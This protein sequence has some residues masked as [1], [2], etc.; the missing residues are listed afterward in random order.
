MKIVTVKN[1]EADKRT[2]V[3]MKTLFGPGAAEQARV[4]MGMAVFPPG[5]RV[6]AEGVGA[7]QEDEYAYV[8]RGSLLTMSGDKEY[9]LSG[10]QAS[11][12]PAGE[13]HW[14]CNDGTEDCE[15]IWALVEKE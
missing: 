2:D 7:H 9:R 12:I 10:G 3:T 4:T 13:A 5:A 6:P 15:L 8:I 1:V 14:S 11:L